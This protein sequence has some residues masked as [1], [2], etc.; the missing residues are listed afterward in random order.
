MD[1]KRFVNETESNKKLLFYAVIVKS[2]RVVQ[3]RSMCDFLGEKLIRDVLLLLN[4]S[5]DEVNRAN[6]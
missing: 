1:Y 2:I 6:A 3:E 5:A 4:V